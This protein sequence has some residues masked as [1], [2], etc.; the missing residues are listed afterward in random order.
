M[1][2]SAVVSSGPLMAPSEKTSFERVNAALKPGGIMCLQGGCGQTHEPL[3]LSSSHT[4]LFLAGC[5]WFALDAIK[6]MLTECQKLY[7]VTSYAHVTITS[8]PCEQIGFVLAGKN[9]VSQWCAGDFSVHSNVW[10]VDSFV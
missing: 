6:E 2:V 1:Q 8:Y 10:I 4:S 3:P 7:P 5:F 9:K